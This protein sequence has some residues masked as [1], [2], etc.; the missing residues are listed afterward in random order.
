MKLLWFTTK[1]RQ[2]SV[3]QQNN[4]K[5][6]RNDMLYYVYNSECIH[7]SSKLFMLEAMNA[8]KS[9]NKPIISATSFKIPRQ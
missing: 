5:I 3:L 1:K 2:S 9:R 4:K 8:F 7:M 6:I